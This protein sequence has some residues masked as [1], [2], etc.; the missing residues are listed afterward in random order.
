LDSG[1]PGTDNV[2]A[3]PPT[4][5]ASFDNVTTTTATT[6]ASSETKIVGVLTYHLQ[7]LQQVG[8]NTIDVVINV[9]TTVD[10]TMAQA[11]QAIT[12][13]PAKSAE[14][15]YSTISSTPDQIKLGISF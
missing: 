14:I 2:I 6:T 4:T 8:Y 5:R 11:N 12:T 7:K 15:T 9:D 13:L 1:I 3:T 10:L